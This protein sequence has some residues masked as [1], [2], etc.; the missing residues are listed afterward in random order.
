VK[1]YANEKRE[2]S[3]SL[4]E[5]QPVSQNN[6]LQLK[7]NR[8]SFVTQKKLAVALSAG[9]S[10]NAIVQKKEQG[11][12]KSRSNE[13][14]IQPKWIKDPKGN[15]W[16]WDDVLDGV[17]WFA[18]PDGRMWFNITDESAIF[19][20]RVADY[21]ALQGKVKTWA[22]WNHIS[23]EPLSEPYNG[24]RTNEMPARKDVAIDAA[25][26]VS[27]G[28]VEQYPLST[29]G[30]SF[31]LGKTRNFDKDESAWNKSKVKKER[32]IGYYQTAR[33]IFPQSTLV[34]LTKLQGDFINKPLGSQ[35]TLYPHIMTMEQL[36]E[37]LLKCREKKFAN[38]DMQA[39]EAALH[40][41][42]GL[43]FK[44]VYIESNKALSH[45]YVVIPPNHL[46]R[47]GALIDPWKGAQL[48][49]ITDELNRTYERNNPGNITHVANMKEWIVNYGAH[50]LNASVMKQLND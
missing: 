3:K 37:C 48:E 43:G 45:N 50:Y 39:M 18:M 22:E 4:F 9:R 42:Y 49:E 7:D 32:A 46:F 38:C 17:T 16:M 28:V 47:N 2:V 36:T 25:N 26:R 14:V 33:S 12:N 1:T 11:I 31:A 29:T 35:E 8:P 44:N 23:V 34:G 40:L 10:L 13:P 27:A 19:K 41:Y 30:Y 6:G 15:D 5:R 24:G 20:G 21:K